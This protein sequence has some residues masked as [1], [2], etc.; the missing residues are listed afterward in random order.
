M[1][2]VRNRGLPWAL[3]QR[4]RKR[5]REESLDENE[6]F[7]ERNVFESRTNRP[8]LDSEEEFKKFMRLRTPMPDSSDGVKKKVN[9]DNIICCC[10]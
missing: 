8:L 3:K 6:R 2:P 5:S 10:W 4:D 1:S 7:L 9:L